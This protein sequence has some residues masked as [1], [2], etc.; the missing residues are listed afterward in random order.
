MAWRYYSNPEIILIVGARIAVLN[1]KETRPC[2]RAKGKEIP[3]SKQ[4]RGKRK[5][6]EADKYD[7]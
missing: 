7:R 1:A 6:P 2:K 3:R 5:P 4:M